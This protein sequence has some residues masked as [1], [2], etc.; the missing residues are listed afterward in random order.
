MIPHLQI[1]AHKIVVANLCLVLV[2]D[3]Q[4]EAFTAEIVRV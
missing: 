3:N 4:I 2:L 1:S